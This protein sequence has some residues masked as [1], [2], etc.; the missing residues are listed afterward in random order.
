MDFSLD[1]TTTFDAPRDLVF[2]TITNI[3]RLPDWNAEIAKVI[4]VGPDLTTGAEWVVEIRAMHTHWT[5]RSTVLEI[6]ADQGRFAY[7]SQSDD[8]NPSYADWR[9]VLSEVDGR[10]RVNVSVSTHP[11]TLFRKA[12]ASRIR[13]AGLRRAMEQS[14]MELGNQ[15]TDGGATGAER[16]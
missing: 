15:F 9:W 7:R 5:S 11:R 14:L 10:C 3:V 6:D 8:G 1:A 13:P 2:R 12:I 4:E 16:A